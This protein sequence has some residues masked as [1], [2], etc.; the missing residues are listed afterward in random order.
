MLDPIKAGNL[1]A[2]FAL[3][4][5]VL[6]ALC[7]WGVKTG[8]GFIGKLALGIGAPLLA[9]VVWGFFIAPKA[10][11]HPPTA[12]WIALQVVVF[13]AAVLSLFATHHPALG[14]ALAI[15]AIANGALLVAWGQ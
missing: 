3:E 15:L 1:G 5:C 14:L 7:Y 4:L 11:Y 10:T 9:A 6:A 8:E 13:G 2:R 12:I